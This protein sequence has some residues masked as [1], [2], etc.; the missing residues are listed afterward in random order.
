MWRFGNKCYLGK[1]KP[2]VENARI[3]RKSTKYT[4]GGHFRHG[5]F[6]IYFA[7]AARIGKVLGVDYIILGSITEFGNETRQQNLGGGGGNFHGFGLGGIGHSNSQANV[8][9]DA[10]IIKTDTAE[11]LAVA[12]GKGESGRLFRRASS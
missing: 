10:G 3:K 11:I 5:A 1:I 7:A 8:V 9:V 12:E 2:V 6:A 4:I